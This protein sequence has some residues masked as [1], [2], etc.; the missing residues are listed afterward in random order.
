M[1]EARFRPLPLWPHGSTPSYARRSRYVFKASWQN[2][3]DLLDRELRQLK[4]RDIVIGCGLREQDIRN[5]GWPRSGAREP[6]HPGVEVSLTTQHGRLV[7]ATDV[8]ERWEHNVRAIALGLE[9]LRAV[10][11]H[12]ITRRGEQYAGFRALP[13]A[14]SEPSVERGRQLIREYGSI[15]AALKATHPDTGGDGVDFKA[16]V[17]AKEMPA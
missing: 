9:A 8:C 16:V 14:T 15:R 3:L 4:A 12:G 6:S 10:D 13:S 5:D 11:R 7:Y 17:A 1:I 2:T